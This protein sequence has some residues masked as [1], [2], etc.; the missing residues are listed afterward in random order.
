MAVHSALQP[1]GHLASCFEKDYKKP[2][3]GFVHVSA[4]IYRI[5]ITDLLLMVERRA[6]ASAPLCR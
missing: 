5:G 3:I 6:L 1:D 4:T 2:W